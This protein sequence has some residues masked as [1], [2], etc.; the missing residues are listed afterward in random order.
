MGK[1][2][3]RQQALAEEAHQEERGV[4]IGN[5]VAGGTAG[6][7]ESPVQAGGRRRW[8]SLIRRVYEAA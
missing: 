8:A 3:P 4:Q 5:D 7:P 6:S 1:D 2:E